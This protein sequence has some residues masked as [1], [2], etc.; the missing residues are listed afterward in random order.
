MKKN[1]LFKMFTPKPIEKDD[2]YLEAPI[3]LKGFFVMLGRKFW[4]ISNLNLLFVFCNFPV[5]FFF[6]GPLKWGALLLLITVPLSNVGSAYI[7]RGYNRMDPIFLYSDFFTAI[8]KNFWQGLLVGFLDILF[9][10][11]LL[12]DLAFWGGI[13]EGFM[14]L[15]CWFGS[16]FLFVVY[17]IMR[18][19]IYTL[20]ITFDLSTY[21][22][23]KNAFIFTVLGFKRNF[24][25]LIGVAL[26]WWIMSFVFVSLLP[27]AIGLCIV[28]VFSLANFITGYASYPVI[29]KYM[30][31]PY[32]TK[33]QYN[34]KRDIGGEVGGDEEDEESEDDKEDDEPVFEDRG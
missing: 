26:L 33:S 27:L 14:P 8:K 24:M 1:S 22:I 28:L 23:F 5:F 16:L 30:I 19:Y 32:Y 21:K 9:V 10:A 3:D 7:I 12:Y 25:A 13:P 20:L 17:N 4:N 31:D 18:F 11:V 15:V 2:E 6:A 29:K 34:K